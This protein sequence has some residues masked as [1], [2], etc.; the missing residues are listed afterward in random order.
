MKFVYSTL[1]GLAASAAIEDDAVLLSTGS[2]RSALGAASMS[3]LVDFASEDS[4]RK[5][6]KLL[7]TFA[8]NTLERNEAVDDV[9]KEKLRDIAAQLTNNTW[10]SLEQAHRRDQDLLNKHWRA[11]KECG[12]KHIAHLQQD[13]DSLEVALVRTH[14]ADMLKCRGLPDHT[15]PFH[16]SLMQ[17]PH[18]FHKEGGLVD[19]V[20]YK[21]TD[22]YGANYGGLSHED[23]EKKYGMTKPEFDSEFSPYQGV[24]A[25][26]RDP[27]TG[28]LN[29][30]RYFKHVSK[31]YEDETN[32]HY[33]SLLERRDE[34]CDACGALDSFLKGL[35]A[36]KPNCEPTLQSSKQEIQCTT[37]E[38]SLI[39]TDLA[40]W[41]DNLIAFSGANLE[42]W[43]ELKAACDEKRAEY[44]KKDEYCDEEQS[45]YE[46]SF[47]AYRQGL[48]STCAEYQGCH[49]LSEEQFLALIQDS[50]YAADSRKIDWKAIHKIA[51]YIKVLVSDG[52]NVQRTLALDNCESGDL[53]TLAT[54]LMGFNESNYL[55]LI[56]PEISGNVSCWDLEVPP[57]IDFKECDM[58]SVHQYPCTETWEDRYVGLVSPAECTA[59]AEMPEHMMYSDKEYQGSNH[60]KSTEYGGGWIFVNELG[61]STEDINDLSEIQPEGYFLP[62]YN[63]KGLRWN[64]VLIQ[65]VSPNWCD[66]WGRQSSKW[67]EDDGAS[68]CIQSDEEK[69]YCTHNGNNKH[70]WRVQPA[71]HFAALCGRE[72]LPACECWPHEEGRENLCFESS[73]PDNQ[74]APHHVTIRSL[75]ED[76]SVVKISFHGEEKVGTLRIG[77]YGSFLDGVGCGAVTPVSYRV[78]V[79]CLG[80]VSERSDF[81][82]KDGVQF[83]SPMDNGLG[84][85]FQ[86]K[87][88]DYTYEAWFR[89]P[90]EGKFRREI[91]GGAETGLMLVNENDDAECKSY[92]DGTNER[93]TYRLHVGNTNA[94][95]STCFQKD[96]M[97]HV[98]VTKK[99]DDVNVYVNGRKVNQFV[100]GTSSCS[101][102]SHSI[103]GGFTD[104]G[105]LFNVRIWDFARSQADIIEDSA[106]T[107]ASLMTSTAGLAHWWPLTGDTQDVMT[108]VHMKGKDVRF[109]PVWCSDLEA[110]GM[111]VC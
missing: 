44:T 84:P 95:S 92:G 65:R 42:K 5:A 14:E 20:E 75:E 68:M 50:L 13:V 6:Q 72:G 78:Y 77:N 25:V 34:A 82:S 47:C 18:E 60:A 99:A 66:S 89:S 53:N 83:N 33:K 90:L 36:A 103:G 98:A 73:H 24:W 80:C 17:V 102:L 63:M 15:N 8:K 26:D 10:M 91:F 27:E 111:R 59:C 32:W 67:V 12:D 40:Q 74:L 93:T 43:R 37:R 62:K 31:Q 94:Y 11:I 58:S 69:V 71:S 28:K 22:L 2:L 96:L 76:G 52:T 104:G 7:Q 56:I 97:Y 88:T 38:E 86:A 49:I 81:H 64:E 4:P 110:T 39:D 106:V 41:F 19:G 3:S 48:H 79:R 35:Q 1:S 109:A 87:R 101:H 61:R 107:D 45:Q 29:G 55:N 100:D 23:F 85:V 21:W 70:T 105:Q 51:C 108:G 54:I 9:T 57:L 46:T 16:Q 30:Q